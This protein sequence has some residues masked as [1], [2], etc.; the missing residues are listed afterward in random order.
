MRG[1]LL[2]Q[3][4]L[5]VL[6]GAQIV[7]AQVVSSALTRGP[8]GKSKGKPPK[9]DKDDDDDDDGDDVTG[10]ANIATDNIATYSPTFVSEAAASSPS[11]IVEEAAEFGTPAMKDVDAKDTVTD[12]SYLVGANDDGLGITEFAVVSPSPSFLPTVKNT[13]PPPEETTQAP[14]N[15]EDTMT[16]TFFPTWQPTSTLSSSI[17]PSSSLSDATVLTVQTNFEIFNFQGLDATDMTKSTKTLEE[18]NESFH[19]FVTSVTDSL[20]EQLASTATTSSVS[21]SQTLPPRLDEFLSEQSRML[22]VELLTDSPRIIDITNVDCPAN[23]F[24]IG[25]TRCAHVLGEYEL[26]IASPNEDKAAVALYYEQATN[27]AIV[28]GTLQD[29]LSQELNEIGIIG[30]VTAT[31]ELQVNTV[32]TESAGRITKDTSIVWLGIL[33]LW[34]ISLVYY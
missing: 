11:A 24:D 14:T 34:G 10:V 27:Q 28:A 23:L 20:A 4:L 17:T 31:A 3:I 29:S 1:D 7:E 6:V 19:R 22:S 2:R 30:P 12:E 13:S 26:A 32:T 33:L 25:K 21:R 16:P 8:R 9:D 18:L 15:V 5:L